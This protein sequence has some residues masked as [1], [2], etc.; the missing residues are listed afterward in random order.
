MLKIKMVV[1]TIEDYQKM[2]AAQRKTVKQ[3]E[4]DE[5]V[6]DEVN[7][8]LQCVIRKELGMH[9]KEL[10]EKLSANDA[11]FKRLKEDNEKLLNENMIIWKVLG[12][13]QRKFTQSKNKE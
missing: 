3:A 12:E 5:H 11:K 2:T 4:L 6:N 8:N 9:S 1:Q 10:D 13:Q 7:V